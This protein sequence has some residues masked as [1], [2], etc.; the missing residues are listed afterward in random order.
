MTKKKFIFWGTGNVAKKF[1]KQHK[2]FLEVVEILGF[3]DNNKENWD[4]LWEGYKVL[5][6][7]VILLQEYDYILI[8]SSKFEEIREGILKKYAVESEKILSVD[9]AYQMYVRDVHG[10]KDGRSFDSCS[11]ISE[12]SF[13]ER[14]C[15]KMLT[16]MD[17]MFSYLY[18]QDR[19]KN[20]IENYKS[21]LSV[22]RCPKFQRVAKKQMPI[23]ICWLQGLE[24]APEI[25]K[26]CINSIV[27]NVVGEIHIIT[28]NN[29]ADYVELSEHIIEKHK[30]GIIDKT[31]FS[32]I[33]R[34]ALLYKY[35]GIWM[36]ATI[37]MMDKGLPN[38]IYECPIFMY[39]IRE[40]L[41]RGYPNPKLFTSWFLK[42][43]KGNVI[44]DMAY[45]MH[46]EWWKVENEIPYC[47]FHYVMRLAW[48]MDKTC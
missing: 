10:A 24:N 17:K 45:K 1:V 16:D 8:M 23:W 42:C 35:G 39:R 14:I 34:L 44:F 11:L 32:D 27:T 29:Y 25:V 36:D 21:K 43:N 22:E 20:F 28:Y 15:D 9:E 26:C 48:T 47:F 18:I 6:P 7:D 37:L 2:R 46:E 12:I 30:L 3:T 4:T 41:D 19:Y 38:Y 13:S 33:L 5:N 40:N 31:H